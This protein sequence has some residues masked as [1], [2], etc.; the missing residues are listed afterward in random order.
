MERTCPSL[1]QNL[2]IEF[3]FVKSN[4]PDLPLLVRYRPKSFL[5]ATKSSP[6]IAQLRLKS[7]DFTKS[8]KS[9]NVAPHPM[10]LPIWAGESLRHHLA[11][12]HITILL[13][14]QLYLWTTT[15]THTHTAN[16]A[17]T[18]H[19]VYVACMARALCICVYVHVCAYIGCS[20]GTVCMSVCILDQGP[21]SV[22]IY[23]YIHT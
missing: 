10:L 5:M 2:L 11:D 13:H 23:I 12:S 19:T 21:I 17:Y 3:N 4:D 18:V 7:L 16:M 15:D 6:I 22:Y 8:T 9:V 20:G 1:G 14:M